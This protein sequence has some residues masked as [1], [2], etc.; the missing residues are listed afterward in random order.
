[1]KTIICDKTGH[2]YRFVGG[3]FISTP[4]Y[5]DNSYESDVEYWGN[6]E[7]IPEHYRADIMNAMANLGMTVKQIHEQINRIEFYEWNEHANEIERNKQFL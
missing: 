3:E 7:Q 1:M 2:A 4:I 6:A 5:N